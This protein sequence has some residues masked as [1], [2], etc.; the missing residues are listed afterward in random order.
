MRMP[1]LDG[2][3]LYRRLQETGHPIT[4]RFV[5]VTGDL[6][7]PETHEFLGQAGTLAVAKPF[8]LSE[9]RQ[10]IRQVFGTETH[11]A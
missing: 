2:A 3:G 7:G 5:F 1:E 11:P 6:L 10:V 4:R 8:V 9:V